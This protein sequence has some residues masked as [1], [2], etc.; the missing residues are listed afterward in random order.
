MAVGWLALL[1]VLA[2]EQLLQQLAFQRQRRL[3]GDLAAGLHRALDAA[4]RHGR[5]VGRTELR[6]VVHHLLHE[7]VD[8]A[9]FDQPVDDA[10][11]VRAIE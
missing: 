10:E 11:L 7:L 8:R 5:L 2:L 1:R 9:G 6:G 3:E 4:H